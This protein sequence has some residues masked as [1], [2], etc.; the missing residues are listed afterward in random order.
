LGTWNRFGVGC[1]T[2]GFRPLCLPLRVRNRSGAGVVVPKKHW[3]SR[4][5]PV[6][7]M[8][9]AEAGILAGVIGFAACKAGS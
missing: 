7:A 6:G 9:N 5:A 1:T 8:R 2:A 4:T 3:F